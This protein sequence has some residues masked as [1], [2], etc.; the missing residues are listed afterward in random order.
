MASFGVKGSHIAQAMALVDAELGAGTFSSLARRAGGDARWDSVNVS[1]SPRH[2][3]GLR[4]AKR[5][6]F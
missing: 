1:A 4:H 3:K 2:E 6:W 5:G